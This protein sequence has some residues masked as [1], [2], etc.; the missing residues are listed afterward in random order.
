M[1][2]WLDEKWREWNN[3]PGSGIFFGGLEFLPG[4]V[5]SLEAQTG[6]G[7]LAK[8]DTYFDNIEKYLFTLGLYFFL[9]GCAMYEYLAEP[10]EIYKVG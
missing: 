5:V 2:G 7:M 9:Y 4:S 10:V 8:F 1:V 6:L 3:L